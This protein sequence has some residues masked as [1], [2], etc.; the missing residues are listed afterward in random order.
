MTFQESFHA[1]LLLVED[2]L[3]RY[4]DSLQPFADLTDA[5]RYSLMAGGKRI[6]PILTLEACRFCGGDPNR[7]LPLAC[8]LEM[9]H[10]YSLI[11]DDL[12]CM[13]D[14]DYR[15]GRPTNHKVY[16]EATAVLAGDGL[17]AAAFSVL[18]ECGLPP[19]QTVAAV[20]CLAEAA[21]PVGM[22]AG[23]ALDMASEG[24]ALSVADIK[25][26]QSLKTGAMIVASVRLGCIAAGVTGDKEDALVE[27]AKKIGLAFQI[28]D[29]ILDVEGDEREL[30]KSVGSD[31]VSEKATFVSL[32]GLEACQKMVNDLT[33]QSVDRLRPFSNSEFLCR[34]AETLAGREK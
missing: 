13:D 11:H 24:Y 31:A 25:E 3:T 9:V 21:G 10:T 32:K 15:R 14:D 23:Q 6:R 5:M 8:A 2:W 16:G 30:G 27:Y 34:L 28:R 29:D 1:D 20:K 18:A 26:L 12:P 4:F 33:N 19:E 22:V 7:A 17:Q